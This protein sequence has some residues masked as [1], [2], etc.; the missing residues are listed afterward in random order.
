MDLDKCHSISLHED[1]FE[2]SENQGLLKQNQNIKYI[3]IKITKRF[4]EGEEGGEAVTD[5]EVDN[6]EPDFADAHEFDVESDDS[7]TK[8]SMRRS[9]SKA[10]NMVMKNN[11]VEKK[12]ASQTCNTEDFRSIEKI[13]IAYRQKTEHVGNV[14]DRNFPISG[15]RFF[16]A[17]TATER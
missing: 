7:E 11:K 12:W 2:S 1:P 16:L 14:S 5:R 9:L 4:G 13:S 15:G 8:R 17:E 6:V 10:V 3:Q